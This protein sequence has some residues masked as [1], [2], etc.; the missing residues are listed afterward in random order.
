MHLEICPIHNFLRC[1][2][3]QY[4]LQ[5]NNPKVAHLWKGYDTACRMY[6][7]GGLACRKYEVKDSAC[8]MKIC[9]MCRNVASQKSYKIANPYIP[10]YVRV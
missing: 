2:M 10:M 9:T 3:S 8:G 6:S 5:K 1:V 7:T 4:L